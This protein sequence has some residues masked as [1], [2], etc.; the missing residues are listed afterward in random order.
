MF[1]KVYPRRKSGGFGALA[2]LYRREHPGTSNVIVDDAVSFGTEY[3]S[4]EALRDV[5]HPILAK[6]IRKLPDVPV[7]QGV[8]L[9]RSP[10]KP[11]D[12]PFIFIQAQ[13]IF[14]GKLVADSDQQT[15]V[16]PQLLADET[17][18][19]KLELWRLMAVLNIHIDP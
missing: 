5:P 12:R 8:R 9:I 19:C 15:F 7:E 18:D 10:W 4:D 2:V 3:L 13:D 16:L 1:I 17:K 14:H 11:R 6:P